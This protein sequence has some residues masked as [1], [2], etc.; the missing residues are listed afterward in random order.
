MSKKNLSISKMKELCQKEGSTF[1]EPSAMKFFGTKIVTK[2]KNNLFITE[3]L[4]KDHRTKKFTVRKFE[5]GEVTSV[6][7][8]LKYSSLA[9][10]KEVLK[11][12]L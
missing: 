12:I 11:T 4:A 9:E 2:P 6:N 7:G 3:D 8:F 5:N 10:A 1:F